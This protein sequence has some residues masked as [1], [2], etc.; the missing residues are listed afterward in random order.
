MQ[1]NNFELKTPLLSYVNSC[2]NAEFLGS[3]FES[4]LNRFTN[5]VTI[6]SQRGKPELGLIEMII[7]SLQSLVMN[8]KQSYQNRRCLLKAFGH[9]KRMNIKALVHG[10]REKNDYLY[11]CIFEVF[12]HV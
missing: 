9:T 12:G 1:I 7:E 4:G 11:K 8:T 6:I 3:I 2:L 10:Y 5:V